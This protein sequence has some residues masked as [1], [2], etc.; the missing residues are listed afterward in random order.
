[1]SKVLIETS[2]RHVH[3]SREDLDILFGEGYELTAKK[4]IKS[5]IIERTQQDLSMKLI[6]SVLIAALISCWVFFHFGLLG[7][8]SQSIVALLIVFVI[9]FLATLLF[10]VLWK[11]L[12]TANARLA[13]EAAV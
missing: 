4:D 12:S 10:S 6:L 7:N 13:A 1:M 5:V 3:V 9:A 11:K 2:A 8:L